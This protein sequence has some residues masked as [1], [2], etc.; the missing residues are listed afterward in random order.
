[1]SENQTKQPEMFS[2]QW[3][4]E[5]FKRAENSAAHAAFCEQVYGKN[6]CQH[7][8][9]DME[10]LDFLVSL[11]QPGSKIVEI[12]CSN[13]YM[14][15]YIQEQTRSQVLGLDYSAIAIQQAQARTQAK[16]DSL[17]FQRVDLTTEAIPGED[18]D[19]AVLIDSVYFLGEP[20]DT[21]KKISSKL[22][23]TGKMIITLF[24]VKDP[25]NE[26][27][28]MPE[29]DTTWLAETL[30]QM[31]LSYDWYDFTANVRAHGIKNFQAGE[32]LKEAFNKEGNS[33]LYESR[34]AENRF[35]KERA[36]QETIVRYMYVVTP[37]SVK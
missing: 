12:G 25:E 19:Y 11:I 4:D 10:E 18:Y 1:M 37:L 16:T 35:F 32:A 8:L 34:A 26:D 15:E 28:P 17:N 9:M 30:N 5:Y 20:E 7:G 31:G 21:V 22:K 33:F 27:S 29:Q 3:Y 36:E 13:G 2:S 14:T 23:P 24:Q 6:L